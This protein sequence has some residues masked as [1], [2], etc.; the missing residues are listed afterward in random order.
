MSSLEQRF[1][2]QVAARRVVRPSVRAVV[3]SSDGERLLVQ[4]PS[5]SPGSNYAFIGR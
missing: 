5:D 2:D 3:L 4:R 1:F